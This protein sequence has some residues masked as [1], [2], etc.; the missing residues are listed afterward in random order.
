MLK[1][2]K[3]SDLP[4]LTI[5]M[6]ERE[7]FFEPRLLKALAIALILHSGALLFFHVT[8]FHFSSTFTFPPI[9][10]QSDSPIQGVS[11]WVSQDIQDPLLLSPP[12]ALLP[13]LDWIPFHQESILTPAL[14]FD[15]DAFKSLEEH[16]WPK[17]QEPLS[18][19][20]NEPRIRL[21]IS[22]DLAH[23]PLIT[24]DPLLTEKQSIYSSK[25]PV[26]VTYQVQVDEKTGEIFWYERTQSSAIATID[27]LTEKILL[28]LR[29]ASQEAKAFMTGA[30]HFAILDA[31]KEVKP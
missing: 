10:V 30:L 12:L 22:G 25:D 2:E 26:Y 20:L 23:V 28:N 29:F 13:P 16:L 8:P 27:Q 24:L 5:R 17:W 15:P 31:G 14:S 4:G 7:H 21:A 11:T 1:L 6:R 3:T 9:Q 18:L 19:P